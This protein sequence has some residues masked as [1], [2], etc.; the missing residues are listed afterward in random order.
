MIIRT[1]MPYWAWSSWMSWPQYHSLSATIRKS[2]SRM[3]RVSVAQWRV[4]WETVA[5]EEAAR[6]SSGFFVRWSWL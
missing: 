6:A 1:S 3:V 5:P 4:I 2:R